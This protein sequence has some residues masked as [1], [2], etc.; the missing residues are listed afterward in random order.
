[1]YCLKES[2]IVNF[3][4]ELGIDLN[5]FAPFP[6]HNEI[7]PYVLYMW[8]NVL[9]RFVDFPSNLS[10]GLVYMINFIRSTGAIIVLVAALENVTAKI[11]FQNVLRFSF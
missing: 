7:S 2:N 10:M 4:P 11:Y 8:V 6:F 5:M 3:I 1:M 9:N